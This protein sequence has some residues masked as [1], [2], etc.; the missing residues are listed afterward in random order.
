MT[1][2]DGLSFLEIPEGSK[3]GTRTHVAAHF[4]V[5]AEVRDE[6]SHNWSLLL[7]W[8]DP[9]GNSHRWIMPRS[10]IHEYGNTIA[11]ELER[12]GLRCAPGRT[13]HEL[14]K[15]Y[16]SEECGATRANGRSCW[17]VSLGC[18]SSVRSA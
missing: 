3:V 10:L 18:G 11:A 12:Q 2:E 8:H 6:A 7:E 4:Q 9:E 5:L 1:K 13:A 16:F 17:M 14:L 15:R